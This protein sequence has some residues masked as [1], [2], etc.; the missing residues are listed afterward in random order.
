M[1]G[2]R[3]YCSI[4]LCYEFLYFLNISKVLCYES[5]YFLTIKGSISAWGMSSY[6]AAIVLIATDLLYLLVVLVLV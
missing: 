5:L 1:Y 4:C 6:I 2:K 3:D